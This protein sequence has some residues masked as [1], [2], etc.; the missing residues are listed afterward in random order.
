MGTVEVE[1][2]GGVPGRHSPLSVTGARSKLK[3]LRLVE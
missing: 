1:T 3:R 2:T